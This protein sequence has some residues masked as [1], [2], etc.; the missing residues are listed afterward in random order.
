MPTN[1]K[2]I[3]VHRVACQKMAGLTL[4]ELLVALA[5]IGILIGLLLPAIQAVRE[6]ARKTGCKNNLKQIGLAFAIHHDTYQHFPTDGWGWQWTGDASRGFNHLQ[7][8]GWCFNILPLVENQTARELASGGAST[9]QLLRTPLSILHCSSRR[10]AQLYPYTALG[11]PLRNSD[12]VFEAARTDY[13]VCA[14]DSIIHTPAGP[15][16]A[17]PS[18]LNTYAWPPFQNATGISYVLSRIRIADVIDGASNTL[19]V[20]E[21]YI[22]RQNYRDGQDL[23][24]DQTAF[25]GDDADIRRWSDKPPRQDTDF[26]D[27]QHFGSA[28]YDGCHFVICDG[29]TRSVHYTI[30]ATVFKNLGNRKDG[31]VIS[32]D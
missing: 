22:N 19:V 31:G 25:L 20:G 7:P 9:A 28:H 3:R 13:A 30:D 21:K 1:R 26:S 4:V 23:G 2:R 5:I 12:Q 17:N 11:L 29:S 27:I 16:S 14:G 24:D 15:T 32:L 10:R 6:A 18:D 8:G